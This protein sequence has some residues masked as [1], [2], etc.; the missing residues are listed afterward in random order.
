M[1]YIYVYMYSINTFFQK[2]KTLIK[3]GQAI[4]LQMLCYI[5]LVFKYD[6]DTRTID[7]WWPNI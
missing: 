1:E 3:V 4:S 6:Q 5:I 7:L 2:L